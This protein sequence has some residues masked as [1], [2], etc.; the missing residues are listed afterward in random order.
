MVASAPRLTD[1]DKDDFVV[2]GGPVLVSDRLILVSSA[3][4][5]CRFAL[6]GQGSQPAWNRLRP[7]ST[8]RCQECLI[9]GQR[10]AAC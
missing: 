1:K 3:G 5:A 4:C 10:R 8:R 7:I 9:S 2:L 6:Y